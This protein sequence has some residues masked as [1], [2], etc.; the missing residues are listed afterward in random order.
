MI[1]STFIFTS[2][3][4]MD[5]AGILSYFNTLVKEDPDL[6]AAVAAIKT[7]LHFLENNKI[8][9]LAEMRD[10]LKEAI[11]ILTE[12]DSSTTSISSAGELFLRFITLT[13]LEHPNIQDCQ[14]I[15]VERGNLFLNKIKNSRQKIAKQAQ[16]FIRDGTTI[17]THSKSRV[18]LQVLKEAQ[19]CN[20][21]FHVYV[22]ES[23]P[24]KSGVDTY[25]ELQKME[26]PATLILDAAVGY[27]MEKVDMVLVGAEG[28]VESGGIINKIGT[29]TMGL[30]AKTMNKPFYVVAESFKFARLYPLNQQDLPNE[31]KYHA[32]TLK[33]S[34]DLRKEHPL[35]DYTPPS[36]ITLLFTD[37]GILTPSAV[38]DELIKLYC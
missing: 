11:Q 20:K 21:R 17:L 24:N 32:S 22:T 35:V 19:Q 36:Y 26:I 2:D 34:P 18:V 1:S 7:L 8:E 5:N 9:T 4:N 3:A 30:T 23:L 15:L 33:S 16:Q 38:S 6:S 28:V 14:R 31:F 25:N 37:L 29:Y 27:V 13:S 10:R 12:T